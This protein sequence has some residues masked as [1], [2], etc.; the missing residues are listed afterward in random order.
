MQYFCFR[1][2]TLIKND[3]KRNFKCTN[4]FKSKTYKTDQNI[5]ERLFHCGHEKDIIY[6]EPVNYGGVTRE[7]KC[8]FSYQDVKEKYLEVT[9][10]IHENIVYDVITIKEFAKYRPPTPQLIV[11]RE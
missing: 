4:H 10:D 8:Q 1:I 6:E 5:C 7:S 3:T 9:K 2:F 11:R